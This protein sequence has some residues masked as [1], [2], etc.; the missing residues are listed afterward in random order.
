MDLYAHR[1]THGQE[2]ISIEGRMQSIMKRRLYKVY[3]LWGI[4]FY[5][6]LRL[7]AWPFTYARDVSFCFLVPRDGLQ[8]SPNPGPEP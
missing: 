5:G 6:I 3:C 1:S 2:S 4:L 8:S 7:Q